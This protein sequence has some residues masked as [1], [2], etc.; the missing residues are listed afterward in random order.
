MN[1]SVRS[2]FP[3]PI[4]P[5]EPTNFTA[6]LPSSYTPPCPHPHRFVSRDACQERDQTETPTAFCLC[7]IIWYRRIHHSPLSAF[8]LFCNTLQGNVEIF[9]SR[10]D[11]SQF[12]EFMRRNC[13]SNEQSTLPFVWTR[14]KKTNITTWSPHCVSTHAITLS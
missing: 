2:L 14:R 10:E 11:P 6:I 8:S 13:I 1:Q 5:L 4:H 7:E 12:N 9:S 3:S